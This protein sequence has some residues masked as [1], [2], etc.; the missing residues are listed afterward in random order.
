MKSYSN[1][2]L[3]Q[4]LYASSLPKIKAS[5]AKNADPNIIDK[6]GLSALLIACGYK[7]AKLR[8]DAVYSLL[9]AGAHDTY[10]PPFGVTTLMLLSRIGDFQCCQLLF[11]RKTMINYQG[12]AGNTA[13]MCAIKSETYSTEH[14]K[15]VKLLLD[16]GADISLVD[17]LNNAPVKMAIQ[18]KRQN[19]VALL[20][21]ILPAS[22]TMNAA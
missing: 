1:N 17:N 12:C 14:D 9:K 18:M 22:E 16:N 2:S 4:G 5:L 6:Y 19:A 13:L 20:S 3:L 10:I 11:R 21:D 15:I 8:Y 7:D